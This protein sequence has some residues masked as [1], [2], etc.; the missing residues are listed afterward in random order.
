M[1]S[2]R[3]DCQI[4][5]RSSAGRKLK[6]GNVFAVLA[7]VSFLFGEV[8]GLGSDESIGVFDMFVDWMV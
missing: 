1:G 6:R 5:W 8:C 3:A 4:W 7:V 2:G